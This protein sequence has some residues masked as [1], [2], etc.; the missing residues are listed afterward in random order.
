MSGR[1]L[2]D[3]MRSGVRPLPDPSRR[4]R[5]FDFALI[6]ITVMALGALGLVGYR[7]WFGNAPQ[8]PIRTAAAATNIPA[9]GEADDAACEARGKTAAADPQTGDHLITNPSIATGVAFLTTRVQCQL[10][11][12]ARRFCA[13]DGKAQ[14]VAIVTDYLNR[15]DMVKLG[16]AAQG[17]P[18]ALAGSLFGG[19]AAAGDDIYSNMAGDTL[20]NMA[21]NDAPVVAA[22]RALAQGGVIDAE[23]FRPFPLAGL[24]SRI[25]AIFANVTPTG[26]LCA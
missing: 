10:T 6:A 7:A 2:V 24:P 22:I 15:M 19:E 13:A 14:L 4:G 5:L 16:I 25:E 12:K 20:A 21:E 26:S 17:A 23:A 8:M 1:D 11:V 18:M 3:E 9:W